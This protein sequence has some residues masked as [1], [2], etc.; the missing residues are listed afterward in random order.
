MSERKNTW[1]REG[2]E[3]IHEVASRLHIGCGFTVSYF[4]N[5]GVH[6]VVKDISTGK[7]YFKEVFQR[8]EKE[9]SC[10]C[11]QLLRMFCFLHRK[12]VT[13]NTKV[14]HPATVVAYC[15]AGSQIQYVVF[16]LSPE[17]A[18]CKSFDLADSGSWAGQTCTESGD[19]GYN[20]G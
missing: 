16:C 11:A 3:G 9:R 1:S 17:G 7:L 8:E 4:L 19:H 2:R 5:K 6:S 13:P 12:L 18:I 14:Y 10:L 20:W 15:K